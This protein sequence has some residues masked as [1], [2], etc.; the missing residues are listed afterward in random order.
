MDPLDAAPRVVIDL[1]SDDGLDDVAIIEGP[2]QK[3][4]S[5][6]ATAGDQLAPRTFHT[7]VAEQRQQF[8]G[9]PQEVIDLDTPRWN[10]DSDQAIEELL[11]PKPEDEENDPRY[12]FE[13]PLVDALE[14]EWSFLDETIR[15]SAA[16]TRAVTPTPSEIP[17]A[18]D[19]LRR[20][21][22][23]FPDI[24]HDHVRGLWNNADLNKFATSRGRYEEV[25]HKILAEDR[26][27][28]QPKT[29][30]SDRKRKRSESPRT[31]TAATDVETYMFPGR[32]CMCGFMMATT[33]LK[34]DFQEMTNQYIYKTASDK[35][36]LFPA[37]LALA[38]A[39]EE[40]ELGYPPAFGRGRITRRPYADDLVGEYGSRPDLRAELEAARRHAVYLARQRAAE[41][42]LKQKEAENIT[43][44][45]AAGAVAECQA[46]FDEMPMNRQIHCD[47]VVAHFTC[48]TCAEAYI[49]AEV[50]QSRCRVMCTAGCG[51]GFAPAQINLLADKE[52]LA[53]LARIQQATDIRNAG[54]EDLEECPFCEYKAIVDVGVDEDS[55][56]RCEAPDCSITSCRRCHAA[57]HLPQTCKEA[58]AERR[59]DGRHRI[60]EA[61][62]AALVRHCNR[63]RQQFIKESGCN[64]MSCSACHNLQCYCC[65]ETVT[66]YT[67][68]ENERVQAAVAA[69]DVAVAGGGPGAQQGA[70]A[71]NGGAGGA[72]AGPGP[73]RKTKCPL[74]DNV[75]ERHKRDIEQAEKLARAAVL[76]ENPN[77]TAEELAINLPADTTQA[78]PAN[79]RQAVHGV[80]HARPLALAPV[81]PVIVAQ[82]RQRDFARFVR[83]QQAFA[84]QQEQM[85]QVQQL[86]RLQL[87]FEERMNATFGAANLQQQQRQLQEE[88]EAVHR[89]Q[90]QLVARLQQQVDQMRRRREPQDLFQEQ[91]NAA[92]FQFDMLRMPLLNG[93]RPAQPPGLFHDGLAGP[94]DAGDANNLFAADWPPRPAPNN[95]R[96][97]GGPRTATTVANGR[98]E[99]IAWPGA[100]IQADRENIQRDH[101]GAFGGDL[102]PGHNELGHGQGIAE[103]AVLNFDPFPNDPLPL[104][105]YAVNGE[106]QLE[107]AERRLDRIDMLRR[108]RLEQTQQRRV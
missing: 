75:E 84:R 58:E 107:L 100:A 96:I 17:D 86:N 32:P 57:T 46:C 1:T 48:Y 76:A 25:I 105:P 50:G 92:N 2:V 91:N 102:G 7:P 87:R 97:P 108:L 31:R 39:R 71:P 55:E 20:A 27:P 37:F 26:Y 49:N 53:R 67:H 82:R 66:D 28:R 19:C 78:T 47:G 51:A 43:V 33:I 35:V 85:L 64:K 12:G 74:Y 54:I 42:A 45:K 68:F 59:L 44:A 79:Q 29:A 65:G 22:A 18:D 4:I 13:L 73:Q 103:R 24:E 34:A 106:L 38:K 5:S 72:G 80:V 56:F 52:L 61:M 16:P 90:Q 70:V 8:H 30:Q 23:M 99:V 104:P 36:N 77:V 41:R 81:D 63:C 15:P 11:R 88:R 10:N 101:Y 40:Y 95:G 89:R 3:G 14:P 21:L 9:M 98:P 94:A 62:T 83:Q 60:E 69:I 6:A 93:Q